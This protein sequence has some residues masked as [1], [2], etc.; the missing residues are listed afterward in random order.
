MCN[1]CENGLPFSHSTEVLDRIHYFFREHSDHQIR[2]YALFNNHIDE[3]KLLWSVKNAIDCF[4]I[5]SYRYKEYKNSAYW[6]LSQHEVESNWFSVERSDAHLKENQINKIQIERASPHQTPA[7]R[8]RILRDEN[9]DKLFITM[10]HTYTDGN[11]FKKFISSVFKSYVNKETNEKN[12][13]VEKL[14]KRDVALSVASLPLLKKLSFLVP[15][16]GDVWNRPWSFDWERFNNRTSKY[17]FM[18]LSA[19]DYKALCEYTCRKNAT[20]NDVMLT[21]FFRAIACVMNNSYNGVPAV[22]VPV[23][24]R[25]H[26]DIPGE[27][28][29]SN[30]CG[31]IRCSAKNVNG[32]SFEETLADVKNSM[33]TSKKKREEFRVVVPFFVMRNIVGYRLFEKMVKNRSGPYAPVFTNL[34]IINADELKNAGVVD[35]RISGSVSLNGPLSVA[36]CTFEN[37]LHFSIGANGTENDH[38]QI[39]K[40][41]QNMQIELS[42]EYLN[43]KKH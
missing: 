20:L 4:P 30:F 18:S 3:K 14:T 26:T 5:L 1:K 6:E 2:F 27:I 19:D 11:G 39:K 15:P 35:A 36:V 32:V 41:L 7:L 37:K 31:M 43:D 28:G 13:S 22:D 29:L 16:F 23:D 8:V 24:L 10:D 40:I 17:T 25:K 34:G 42:A 21:A 33:D 12:V 9:K 38:C